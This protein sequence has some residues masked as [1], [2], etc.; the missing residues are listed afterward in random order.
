MKP[1]KCLPWHL[2]T[3]VP[4]LIRYI[5]GSSPVRA[6]ISVENLSASASG[7]VGLR[8]GVALGKVVFPYLPHVIT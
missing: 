2:I 7:G 6:L 8:Y 1:F 4:S 3:I 5:F